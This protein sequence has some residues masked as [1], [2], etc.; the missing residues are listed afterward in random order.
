MLKDP[1][2]I[3]VPA[4]CQ[5][6]CQV[7]IPNSPGPVWSKE[8]YQNALNLSPEE[9]TS[10]KFKNMHRAGCINQG[11]KCALEPGDQD[12][13][14]QVQR[15]LSQVQALPAEKICLPNCLCIKMSMGNIA[16]M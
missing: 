9:Q 10:K 4:E 14:I 11:A 8:D 7:G 2:N 1:D 6:F 13:H 5:K 3:V 16:G 15:P 12:V